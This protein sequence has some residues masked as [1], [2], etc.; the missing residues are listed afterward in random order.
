LEEDLLKPRYSLLLLDFD[1]TLCASRPAIEHCMKRVLER[2]IG[3]VPS[4]AEILS[5][6]SA[7]LGLEDSF[8]VLA[9]GAISKSSELLARLVDEYRA[10]YL[11]EGEQ[12]TGMYAGW[13]SALAE[14][15]SL[16]VQTAIVSN[17]SVAAIDTTLAR[18]GFERWMTLVVGQAPGI[19][20]K[21]DPRLFEKFIAPKF[22]DLVRSEMLVIGDTAADLEF[23]RNI[24]ADCC[25][26]AFGYGHVEEC[27][28]FR[29]EHT[30]RAVEELVDIVRGM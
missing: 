22:P 19:P 30:V 12:L 14:F 3:V 25:W 23:A 9:P 5:T 2:S 27:E 6:I 28:R 7:G 17:K 24:G 15:Q 8:R 1:G 4:A 13:K 16:N 26:A 10:L 20:R 18:F 11:V 29:P 21:P